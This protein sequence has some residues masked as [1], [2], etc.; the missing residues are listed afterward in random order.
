[1]AGKTPDT[2]PDYRGFF[3][4]LGEPHSRRT[5]LKAAGI[6]GGAL[7]ANHFATELSS[8]T[9]TPSPLPGGKQVYGETTPVSNWNGLV[10]QLEG[11]TASRRVANPGFKVHRAVSTGE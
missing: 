9:E 4:S 10:T 5:L 11:E 8:A 1:M 2:R 3:R 6:A 7:V